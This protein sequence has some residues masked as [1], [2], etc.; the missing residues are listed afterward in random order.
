[1]GSLTVRGQGRSDFSLATKLKSREEQALA[2]DPTRV[3]SNIPTDVKDIGTKYGG[4]G[5]RLCFDLAALALAGG[6][7]YG[8]T[9]L[10]AYWAAPISLA[11]LV[12]LSLLGKR[13]FHNFRYQ[14]AAGAALAGAVAAALLGSTGIGIGITILCAV[15]AVMCLAGYIIIEMV[16]D[17]FS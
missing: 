12:A 9:Q 1:M 13:L 14:V 3:G 10:A 2:I 15:I 5:T 17:Q 8:L 7:F 4:S 6:C 11:L 16:F